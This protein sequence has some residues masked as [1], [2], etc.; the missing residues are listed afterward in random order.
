MH[1]WT[2]K[3]LFIESNVTG[4]LITGE[5][6]HKSSINLFC[7]TFAMSGLFP[8]D[9]QINIWGFGIHP[10]PSSFYRSNSSSKMTPK[11]GVST[12]QKK[13]GALGLTFKK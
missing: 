4:E 13:L 5:L 6:L 9:Y 11:H 10:G 7:A 8:K 1:R 12:I 2:Y 3:L